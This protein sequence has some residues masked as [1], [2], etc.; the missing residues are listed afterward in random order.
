MI[1]YTESQ[2]CMKLTEFTHQ[3]QRDKILK[4]LIDNDF[5]S[6]AQLRLFA[7]QY[8]ARIYELRKSGFDI[9]TARKDGKWGFTLEARR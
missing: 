6:T 1:K 3:T 4:L 9:K 8:N 7:Y 5:V 2:K